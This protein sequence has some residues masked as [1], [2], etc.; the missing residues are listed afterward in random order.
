MI[1]FMRRATGVVAALSALVLATACTTNGAGTT[2][3][4]AADQPSTSLA[5][6]AAPAGESTPSEPSS[7]DAVPPDAPAS[8]GVEPSEE[9]PVDEAAEADEADESAEP[10]EPTEAA[11][12]STSPP[13]PAAGWVDGTLIKRGEHGPTVLALQ[14]RLSQ[15]AYD[16]G[17]Q[18]SRF[19]MQTRQ[20]LWAFQ[21]V[22]DLKATGV[23]DDVTS[24]ALAAPALP[25]VLAKG[26]TAAIASRVEVN[27]AKQ[28]AVVYLAGKIRLITHIS[29]GSGK[30]WCEKDLAGKLRCASG[31]TPRGQYK[32]HFER[33]GWRT[34]YLGKLYQ[35]AYFKGGYA[36]HGS[37][38][39]P[40]YPASHGCVRI[41]MHV[42][43]YLVDLTEIGMPVTVV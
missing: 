10:S 31:G 42:A 35:P 15:L 38:S 7:E 20:A 6:A 4:A 30:K 2:S 36:L 9:A 39:V 13:P 21:H 34:S 17:R 18:D 43:E 22:N 14:R 27:I 24:S 3:A 33:Q 5:S 41:P 16:P 28:Y 32:V 25:P 11:S 8:D 40:N 29:S 12:A 26:K 1:S 37:L 19:G 23:V